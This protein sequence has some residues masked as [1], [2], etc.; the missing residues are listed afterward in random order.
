MLAEVKINSD[1]LANSVRG[2]TLCKRQKI[3][4]GD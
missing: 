3:A 2:N 1:G 4:T